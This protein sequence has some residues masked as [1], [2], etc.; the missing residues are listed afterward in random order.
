MVR[1]GID[2]HIVRFDDLMEIRP[3]FLA[4]VFVW[5]DGLIVKSHAA[6]MLPNVAVVALHEEVAHVF[7]EG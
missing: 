7:C 6:T 1:D 5:D 3:A 4:V 2:V